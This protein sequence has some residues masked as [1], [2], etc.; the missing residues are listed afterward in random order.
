MYQDIIDFENGQPVYA[1]VAYPIDYL[2]PFDMETYDVP[3]GTQIIYRQNHPFSEYL[4][5]V[6]KFDFFLLRIGLAKLSMWLG[7]NPIKPTIKLIQSKECSITDKAGNLLGVKCRLNRLCIGTLFFLPPTSEVPVNEGINDILEACGRT[8]KEI[9]PEWISTVP[10]HGLTN[11]SRNIARLESIKNRATERI[12]SAEIKRQL[13]VNHYRLLFSTD[14]SLVN[15]VYE[16]FSLL[17]FK[18]LKDGRS[19][20]KEDSIFESNKVDEPTIGVIEVKGLN[21]RLKKGH[22]D[23]CNGWVTDYKN[24]GKNAKGILIPNQFRYKPYIDSKQERL[25]F[26]NN[27]RNLASARKICVFPSTVLFETVNQILR[28]KKGSRKDVEK[29]LL[30]TNGVLSLIT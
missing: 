16:A 30:E 1:P 17:G 8:T 25:D 18:N 27:I 24:M 3:E 15:A 26:D 22:I 9:F 4:K 21:G 6:K 12:S 2:C 23:Q 19:P 10:L 14:K 13:L 7:I 28:G 5:N 11:I 20:D 29:L